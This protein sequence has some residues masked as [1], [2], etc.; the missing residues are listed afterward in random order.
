M[1][2]SMK[3]RGAMAG[4]AVLVCSVAPSVA[5]GQAA[6]A[7]AVTKAKLT[8]R[9]ASGTPVSF[10]VYLPLQDRAGLESL[11]QQLNTQGGPMYHKWLT[12]EQ[13][14]QRFS[15]KA[16]KLAAAQAELQRQG[17]TA[18][19]VSPTH[20]EVTGT[21]GATEQALHTQ[22]FNGVMSNGATRTVTTTKPVLPASLQQMGAV[23]TG[24]SDR[25][26]MKK[27]SMVA[28]QNR[29]S[30][31]GP[32]WFTDLKQAYDWPSYKAYT[33]KGVTIGILMTGDYQ[34]SDMDLYFGHEKLATPKISEVKIKGGAPFDPVGSDETHLDLQQSGGMA[35]NAK[36]IL[37]NM[38]DLGDDNIIKA[39]EKIVN[40]NKTDVVSMSF[41]GPEAAYL[42]EF[43]DGQDE[44]ATLQQEDDL[45]AQGNAQGITFIASSGDSG[46]LVVP[47]VA[48]FTN[49]DPTAPCGAYQ[50]GVQFPASSPHVVGV[51]GTNL[52]T[53]YSANNLDS[54][55]VSEQAFA[56]PL[57]SDIFYGT[58]ATGGYWGSGGGDSVVFK[59]PL[60]QFLVNTGNAKM[61]TVPDVA[62]HMGG[63]PAGTVNDVC[64]PED[65]SVAAAIGGKLI[66]LIG[67][68]AAAPDFAGLTALNVERFGTRLGNENYYVYALAAA[69]NIGIGPKVFRQGIPGF[70]GYYSTTAKGYDRVLGNGTVDGRQFLLAPE[71][72][73]AGTPQ[74]P[75]NP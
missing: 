35:P 43:N 54:K 34:A 41:G 44:T 5:A 71:V 53:T 10:D 20:L 24:F 19:A 3:L 75:S 27:H 68:S 60:F 16:D 52:V 61:R 12:P 58:A 38:P 40:Q 21:S 63:C 9:V 25:V 29:Y 67:T 65:S 2:L 56:D 30:S 62:L 42:P 17:L 31:G 8:S 51:G 36:L 14:H 22:I 6:A 64:N 33:G 13:F 1:F 50:P 26:H 23:V 18:T 28:P 59:K 7:K 47:P 46:G 72:K 48:C 73:A 11:I 15:V 66:A 57:A 4:A 49:E 37:Y 55:Y 70:N 32:Y 74:T 69:Q 39:L 45:F